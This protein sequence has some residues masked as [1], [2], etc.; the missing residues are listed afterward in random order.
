V[1][2][3]L[4]SELTKIGIQSPSEQISNPDNSKILKDKKELLR[5]FKENFSDVQTKDQEDQIIK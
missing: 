4:Q 2:K 1:I 3:N 5:L